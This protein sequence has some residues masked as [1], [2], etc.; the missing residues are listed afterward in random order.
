MSKPAT[1]PRWATDVGTTVEPFAGHKNTGWAELERPP[2]KY[3]NW[4]FNTIYSWLVYFDTDTDERLHSR[5]MESLANT[6]DISNG[7]TVNYN[8]IANLWLDPQPVLL[9]VADTGV[10]RTSVDWGRTWTTRTAAAAYAGTWRAAVNNGSAGFIAVGSA[11]EIQTGNATGAAWTHR[12]QAGAYAGTFVGLAIG[13]GNIVAIGQ[14]AAQIQYSSNGGVSWT[15]ATLPGGMTAPCAITYGAGLFVVVDSAAKVLATSPTGATWT[16]RTA[17]S[18]ASDGFVDVK[19]CASISKFLALADNSGS[20]LPYLHSSADGIA[21]TSVADSWAQFSYAIAPTR[22]GILIFSA[23]ASPDV[24][25]T[26]DGAT[27][28][29][30][31]GTVGLPLLLNTHQSILAAEEATKYTTVLMSGSVAA[32]LYRSALIADGS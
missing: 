1:L 21:W 18:D 2:A 27:L 3:F 13:G 6:V 26:F 30:G 4:L 17:A 11:G 14:S 9:I 32:T 15:A 7:V 8:G 20:N 29:D 5:L 12:T 19:W 28:V 24:Q 10:L 31:F 22:H 16:L 25:V 23:G